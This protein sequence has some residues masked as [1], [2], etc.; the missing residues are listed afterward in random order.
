MA[1]RRSKSVDLTK[2]FQNGEGLKVL[3]GAPRD[4]CDFEFA[5]LIPAYGIV[6]YLDRLSRRFLK[7]KTCVPDAVYFLGLIGWN[8]GMA[9]ATYKVLN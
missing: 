3:A 7:T 2:V 6:N 1:R 5:D 9:Y 8:A 4:K